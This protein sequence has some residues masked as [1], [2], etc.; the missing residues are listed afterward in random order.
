MNE[1]TYNETTHKIYTVNNWYYEMNDNHN[2]DFSV[3]DKKNIIK[4]LINWIKN[5]EMYLMENNN[6]FYWY[7][8]FNNAKETYEINNSDLKNDDLN[9]N[10]EKYTD[11]NLQ[12][13]LLKFSEYDLQNFIIAMINPKY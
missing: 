10:I 12:N 8:I 1:I 9:I 7:A 6:D 5:D 3:F 11:K 13:E 2:Y 4:N